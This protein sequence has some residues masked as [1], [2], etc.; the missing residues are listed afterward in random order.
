MNKDGMTQEQKAY[1]E[2]LE[3]ALE[4]K[5][6]EAE[7]LANQMAKV[8]QREEKAKEA[9]LKLMKSILGTDTLVHLFQLQQEEVN[10]ASRVLFDLYAKAEEEE[11][12][13]DDDDIY[14]EEE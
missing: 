2:G 11:E 4:V 7:S 14:C 8:I 10:E 13:E 12:I 6:I 9:G 1:V 3:A 5:T